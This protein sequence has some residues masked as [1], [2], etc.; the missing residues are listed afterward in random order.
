MIASNAIQSTPNSRRAS[1]RVMSSTSGIAPTSVVRPHTTFAASWAPAIHRIVPTV[2]PTTAQTS[3]NP[4]MLNRVLFTDASG[5]S[6]GGAA[7][8]ASGRSP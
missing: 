6:R 3:Q 1:E 7:P 5:A 2:T 8:S 4:S